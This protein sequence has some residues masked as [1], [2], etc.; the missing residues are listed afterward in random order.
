VSCGQPAPTCRGPARCQGGVPLPQEP[1]GRGCVRTSLFDPVPNPRYLRARSHRRLKALLMAAIGENLRAL[2]QPAGVLAEILWVGDAIAARENPGADAPHAS[3]LRE[4]GRRRRCAYVLHPVPPR[5]SHEVP[6]P[7]AKR[8][9]LP[10]THTPWCAWPPTHK[11]SVLNSTAHTTPD[12]S[13]V[14]SPSV[15]PGSH[16][17]IPPAHP[18]NLRPWLRHSKPIIPAS[19]ANTGGFLQVAVS[20]ARRAACLLFRNM[21]DPAR[22]PYST[23]TS[24]DSGV[25]LL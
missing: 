6:L 5:G 3:S 15:L 25:A 20:K 11:P 10:T 12:P 2:A 23:K 13:R 16:K 14:H 4:V 18:L 22:F 9:R 17:L 7:H 21:L 19:A 8:P 24:G 1:A